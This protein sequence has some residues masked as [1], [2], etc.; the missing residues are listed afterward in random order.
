MLCMTWLTTDWPTSLMVFS[1]AFT[2]RLRALVASIELLVLSSQHLTSISTRCFI[3]SSC[4]SSLFT[5][6][7]RFSNATLEAFVQS[8]SSNLASACV[9]SERTVSKELT[10]PTHIST[11]GLR[12]VCKSYM[13]WYEQ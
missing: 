6:A 7:S 12:S 5:L 13:C 3:S 11:L 10:L 2:L 8:T 9:C 1:Y 4:K